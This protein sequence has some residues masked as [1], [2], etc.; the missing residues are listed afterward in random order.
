M[1]N[2][3]NFIEL[4]W[5][6]EN[7]TFIERLIAERI[8]TPHS[9][10]EAINQMYGVDLILLQKRWS[11]IPERK[12]PENATLRLYQKDAIDGVNFGP[13]K[14]WLEIRFKA[15]ILVEKWNFNLP[16]YDDLFGLKS[17][18]S[19]NLVSC[20]VFNTDSELAAM[21]EAYN[22]EYIPDEQRIF[23]CDIAFYFDKITK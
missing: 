6:N 23:Q 5:P 3:N 7:I 18:S 10:Q 14:D 22:N 17:D 1:S 11:H 19:S 15:R 21:V 8:C 20:R 2:S 13:R 4:D 9:V 12:R 16:I